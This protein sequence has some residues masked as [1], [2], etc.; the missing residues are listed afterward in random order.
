M[1]LLFNGRETPPT[2]PTGKHGGGSIM[3][4]D[5]FAASGKGVWVPLKMK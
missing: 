5:F 1:L 4:W 3:M 2:L